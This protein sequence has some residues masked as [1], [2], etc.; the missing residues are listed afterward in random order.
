[1]NQDDIY[2]RHLFYADEKGTTGSAITFFE[3]P[4]LPRGQVGLT[5]PHHLAYTVPKLDALPKW[6]S[7]LLSHG[8]S[9]VGPLPRDG[10]I[11]LYLR[12]PDG[13]VVEVTSP[14]REVISPDYIHEFSRNLPTVKE[15]TPDMRLTT[16]NHASPITTDPQP[17]VR[18][19][20][21]LLGLKNYFTLENPDQENTAIVAVGNEQRPD[22]LRYLAS[23]KAQE[24]RVGK[25]SIH[26][27]AMAV[28]DEED[29]RQIMRH[30]NTAGVGNSGII[31][32]FW[33]RSLY[34][35]DPDGNLLEVATKGPGYTT[36]E[37]LNSLGT[38]LVLPAWL[39]PKRPEIQTRLNELDRRNAGEWPPKYP[40]VHTP[41]ES[42]M[43]ASAG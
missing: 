8:L 29:Q 36:D 27:I 14:N 38:R 6:K 4:D 43:G 19:L 39:E 42:L 16:F 32:R 25:G 1:M 11:S 2:H 26:H 33:F 13:V 18:F 30:L 9:T 21:K 5:S 3:W 12:D 23:S 17:T 40:P 37:P 20:N 34:F 7:W 22:F 31:N 41:P 35:R 15:I 10:R 24:G 28:E